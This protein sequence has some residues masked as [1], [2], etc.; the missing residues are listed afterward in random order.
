MQTQMFFFADVL[1]RSAEQPIAIPFAAVWT[2]GK[3]YTYT[4]VFGKGNGGYDPTTG[5]DVLV[6][7]DFEITVDDF[8]KVINSDTDVPMNEM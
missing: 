6:P 1:L 7:I 4:F 8:V 3:K 2:Q 5:D